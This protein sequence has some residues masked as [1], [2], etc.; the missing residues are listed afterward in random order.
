MIE[1][2][3]HIAIATGQSLFA[4]GVDPAELL[5]CGCDSTQVQDS[6]HKATIKVP[7]SSFVRRWP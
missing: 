2:K 1:G 3:Q 5:K 7:T 4:F 6:H